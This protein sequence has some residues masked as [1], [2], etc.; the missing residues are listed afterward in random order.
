M[1]SSRGLHLP[2]VI[3]SCLVT[4]HFLILFEEVLLLEV[5]F[6]LLLLFRNE[7]QIFGHEGIALLGGPHRSR[8]VEHLLGQL[9]GSVTKMDHLGLVWPDLTQER[10]H[11]VLHHLAAFRV[12]DALN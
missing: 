7:L 2:H 11:D 12:M 6:K 8:C 5:S 10:S 3:E 4:G 1:A 9:P